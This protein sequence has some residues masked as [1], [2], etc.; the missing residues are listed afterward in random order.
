MLSIANPNIARE[1]RCKVK[2]KSV[3][4]YLTSS[5]SSESGSG[6][7]FESGSNNK[8]ATYITRAKKPFRQTN[9]AFPVS[10]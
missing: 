2:K 3:L 1:Q 10:F 4:N 6:S 5:S 8:M 9:S 7:E